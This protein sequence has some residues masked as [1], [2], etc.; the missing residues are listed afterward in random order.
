[1]KR[2]Y[3]S[4]IP[5]LAFNFNAKEVNANIQNINKV[6]QNT[7]RDSINFKDFQKN[8]DFFIQSQFNNFINLISQ[9]VNSSEINNQNLNILNIISDNQ[10]KTEGKFIAE[11][12][13]Q[14]RE[15]NMYLQSDK[16]VYDLEKKI[17]TL[18]GGIKFISDE[19]F[20]QASEVKYNLATKEGH[21]KNIYGTINFDTLT[22]INKVNS[23]ND[24][25]SE[26][27]SSIKNVKLN[28]SSSLEFDDIS[29]PQNLKLEINQMTKWRFQSKEIKIKKNIWSSEVLYLT[30]DP[31][32]KPQ[33]VFKN[34]KFQ[35]SEEDGNYTAKSK[36]SSIILEDK[37]KV[38][39]GP[40]N[41]ESKKGSDFKW[42]IGY[43]GHSKDGL[44]ITRYSEPISFG[45][46]FLNLENEF[47]IQRAISGKTKSFSKENDSVL[48]EKV[49]QD[50]KISDYF[51]IN[52]DI[53]SNILGLKFDSKISLNSLDLEKFKKIIKVNTNLSKVLHQSKTKDLE[54]NTK[55]SFFGI[56]RDS[57]WNGSIGEKDILTAYGLKIENNKN[58]G[59]NKVSKA[60][61]L[62]ASYGEYQSNKKSTKDNLISRERLNILWFREHTYHILNSKEE[63]S[64]TKE[65]SY[66]P[67]P[68]NKGLDLLLS[69]KLD[70]YN[71]SDGKFQNLI[72]FK[73]GP[74]ITLGEFRKKY[75]DY[76]E[77]SILGKTTIANGESPFDFDQS[78]DKHSIE[79]DLKQ[80][81][82]GPLVLKYSTEYN[83]DLNSSNFHKFSKHKYELS[84]N[85]RAYNIGFFYNQERKAAG[86]NFEI[87]GFNFSGYGDNFKKESSI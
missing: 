8:N 14:I 25:F 58:W 83:L 40:R 33:L 60:S 5:F 17:V 7:L 86:I 67:E 72:T 29:E 75:L 10:V 79:I 43:D 2:K 34:S 61:N 21:I 81:L 47:Y 49:E 57:V 32:N 45:E 19:Q 36:W 51:G 23:G 62:A 28:K 80:Q 4:L 13:V 12:N 63:S 55:L 27:N 68:T 76:S 73:A 70:I 46:V 56:Y 37:L 74:K 53:T 64:I 42:G 44:Y 48:A 69:S 1:M 20:F 24:K 16:L 54:E 65:F 18:S 71:Y 15:N 30:N 50:A 11:G 66:V 52:A 77:V 26:F 22:L 84:W 87:N 82:I 78:V 39:I 59:D 31:Y 9:E 35:I 41:F 6:N 85:R 38:P 3:L